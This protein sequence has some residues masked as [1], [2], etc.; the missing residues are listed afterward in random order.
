MRLK[1]NKYS[2]K[3]VNKIKIY[4]FLSIYLLHCIDTTT[5]TTTTTT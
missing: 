2:I 5:T 1:I 4:T 3:K